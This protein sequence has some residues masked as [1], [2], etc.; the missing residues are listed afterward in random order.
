MSYK[1]ALEIYKNIHQ[2]AAIANCIKSI[3]DVHLTLNNY[4][5]AYDNYNKAITL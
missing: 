3:G 4:D 2:K 1:T 5:D